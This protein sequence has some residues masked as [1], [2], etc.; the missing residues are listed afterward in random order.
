[1]PVPAYQTRILTPRDYPPPK[2]LGGG[3]FVTTE[4][5]IDPPGTRLPANGDLK[6]GA[7]RPTGLCN[8]RISMATINTQQSTFSIYPG[9]GRILVLLSGSGM[10]L[11]HLMGE[12]PLSKTIFRPLDEPYPFE[13]GWVTQCNLLGEPP[14]VDFNVI[15]DQ[16]R[17]S[18]AV[19]VFQPTDDGQYID[20]GGPLHFFYVAQGAVVV[21]VPN[22]KKLD[23]HELSTSS[24]L[25]FDS[26]GQ[27]LAGMNFI[28][29]RMRDDPKGG[30]LPIVIGVAV[31]FRPLAEK[32][33][34]GI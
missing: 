33:G 22:G 25:V 20:L 9:Y 14:A 30:A 21:D 28:R 16:A 3:V 17:V 26:R 23:T 31:Q 19:Q 4:L 1:M 15:Y 27:P 8:V 10:R 24:S 7:P 34:S 12:I 2:T 29:P 6:P 32:G 18:A 5:F 11:D 13:G